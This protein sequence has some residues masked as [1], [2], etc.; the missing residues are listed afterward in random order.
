MHNQPLE[1]ARL[2]RESGPG[3]IAVRTGGSPVET[4]SGA[5]PILHVRLDPRQR[6]AAP[7]PAPAAPHILLRPSNGRLWPDMQELVQYRHLLWELVAR[8]IRVNFEA[9]NFAF[10]WPSARPL[11]YV[12]VFTTFRHL[13]S[14]KIG[15]ELPYVLYVYSGLI[16]W[17][18]FIEAAR[19]AAAALRADAPLLTKVYYP[20]V[21]SCAAPVIAG[22][23]SLGATFLP[24]VVMMAWTETWPGWRLIFLPLVIVQVMALAL[25]FG[26]IF[27]A[28]SLRYRDWDRVMQLCLYPGLWLSPVIYGPAMIPEWI[29]PAYLANPIAGS[30]L[31]FRLALFDNFET[32]LWPCLLSAV[33]ALGVLLL[34][35]RMFSRAEHLLVDRV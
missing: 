35:L 10:L 25:G 34:G 13:S 27:A 6:I 32:L 15:V 9:L 22:L 7:A 14:A 33:V 20:R 18:Y 21:L 24:L 31:A 30:L 26:L 23:A 29:R 4:G 1:P 2:T 16:L 19:G 11:L 17:Y 3:T 12:F 28:L 8:N 5:T